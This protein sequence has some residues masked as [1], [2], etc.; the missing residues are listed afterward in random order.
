MYR[1]QIELD[2]TIRHELL[3]FLETGPNYIGNWHDHPFAET[4]Y[5][6]NGTFT[7]EFENQTVNLSSNQAIII[8]P[9]T[10]HRMT[11]CNNAS[12]L[13][14]GCSYIYLGKFIPFPK[15]HSEEISNSSALKLLKN[16][17]EKHREDI[18]LENSSHFLIPLDFYWCSLVKKENLTEN[19]DIMMERIKEYLALHPNEQISVPKVAEKFYLS[20][21]YL[22][23]KF[24]KYTGMSIKQYHLRLRM[25][26]AL[27]LIKSSSMSLSE[28]SDKLGFNTLQYFSS[29]FK[30][31]FGISPSAIIR[32][33][34]SS[35]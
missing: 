5:V 35:F 24:C 11:C 31:H 8:R 33:N 10:K 29:C 12:I 6:I 21:H 22:G 34:K 25:E 7:L 18:S 23:N 15:Q 2:G 28:I 26:Q 20:P 27:Y 32:N 9:Q 14:I 19:F 17:A 13:Y 1:K 16:I 4:I 3:G 30:A